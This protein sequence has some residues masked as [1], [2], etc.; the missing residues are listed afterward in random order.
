MDL[1]FIASGAL[2]GFLVGL[3]GVGGGALMTPI[4]VLVF[5]V[6]P[7]S[8]VRTDLWFAAI[9]KLFA[10]RIHRGRG[11][12]DWVVVRRLWAGSLTASALT[13][14]WMAYHSVDADAVRLLTGAIALVVMVMAVGLLFQGVLQRLGER[15]R[16]GGAE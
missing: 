8:A 4:L 9:T 16:A 15:L 13:L 2:T 3:T 14:V 12:V 10:T 6:A 7:L 1:G 11:L 5:G